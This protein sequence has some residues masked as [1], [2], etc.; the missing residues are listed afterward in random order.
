MLDE[1]KVITENEVIVE[2]EMA[3]QTIEPAGG[4]GEPLTEA[5]LER[6]R[7]EEENELLRKELEYIKE[8]NLKE[9]MYDHVHVSVRTMDI[10]IGVMVVLFFVVIAL[11]LVNR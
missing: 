5:E 7:L 4:A 9:R 8:K 10:F 1:K 6:I 11:G 3:E 2:K